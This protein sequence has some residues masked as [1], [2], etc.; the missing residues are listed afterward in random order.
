[1]PV[2]A[3]ILLCVL[4]A[5]ATAWCMARAEVGMPLLPVLTRAPEED[6]WRHR[7]TPEEARRVCSRIGV[8]LH[9]LRIVTVTVDRLGTGPSVRWFN[10]WEIR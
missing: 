7:A 9:H 3:A 6:E 4:S 5:T 10:R 2:S 8:V 1:M